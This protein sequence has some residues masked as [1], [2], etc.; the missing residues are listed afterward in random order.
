EMLGVETVMPHPEKYDLTALRVLIDR[1]TVSDDPDLESR[2]ADSV[3]TAFSYGAGVCEVLELP[4]QETPPAEGAEPTSIIS[5]IHPTPPAEGVSVSG[6]RKGEVAVSQAVRKFRVTLFSNRFEA[7]GIT[8]EK[9][10]EYLFSF[11]NPLGACPRCEGY[12]KVTGIDENLVVPD[13]SKSIY[14]NAIACWRGETM[15]WWRDQLVL[16]A[17]EFDFPIHRPYYDLTREER[18]ILWRGNTYFHGLDEFFRY[19]EGERYKIQY[20]VMLSR[21]TGKTTC[22]DCGGARLRPEA[23]CVKVGDRTIAELAVLSVTELSAFFTTLVLTLHEQQVGARILTEIKNRLQYLLDVGLGYLTLGRLSS[24]LSG[25]ESQRI[26]LSRSLG[27]SLVGSLYILDE[28][29]IGLHPRDTHRL[30]HVLKQLRDI[31]NTVI[32]VEHEEEIIRAAD[33]IIDIGPRAGIDAM[34][35]EK[36]IFTGSSYRGFY[37]TASPNGKTYHGFRGSVV[38]KPMD[39]I[40]TSK[41]ITI[42]RVSVVQKKYC[43]MYPSDHF[44]IVLTCKK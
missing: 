19:L 16:H 31:G 6:L 11:N 40:F 2:V 8:F 36:G 1:F 14:D 28:P 29:S 10:E 30:I 26:N 24:T 18:Q 38:G 4:G 43:G 15:K 21:Y 20:R 13:K 34:S 37:S 7:D 22:P 39:Y 42:E 9:P 27:S 35:E 33:T 3:Q 32:V 17:A 25:G 12:G 41:E 23:L 44:P 5:A